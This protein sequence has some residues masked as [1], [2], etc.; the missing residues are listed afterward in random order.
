M[1]DPI[2]LRTFLAVVAE[3]GFSAAAR[4]LDLGQSTVSGHIA[5]LE[6]AAGRVL[7]RRDTHSV[8]LTADGSAMVGF[9][10][11]ILNECDRAAAYF[12]D[13][14]LAGRVRFGASED[15]VAARLPTVLRR[16]RAD[17]PRIELELTIGLS[18]DLHTKLRT[19]SLDVVL[20]KRNPGEQH[21]TLI[22]TEPLIWAGAPE[23]RIRSGE[24]VPLVTFPEPSISRTAALQALA[25][26]GLDHR[27]TCVSNNQ[28]G[29]RAAVLAGLG[30]M[31]HAR[32][33]LPPG[34]V[35]IDVLPDPGLTEVVLITRS[36]P[37]T[38]AEQALHDVLRSAQW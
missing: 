1:L 31:V 6:K 7:L 25:G 2:A 20:A 5:R 33:L 21:G 14:A 17:H 36:R 23:T 8:E 37:A 26:A 12:A 18:A 11:S 32:R 30:V 24:P 19:G 35:E 15:L 13:E 3:G 28:Q 10:R 38:P 16:F 34:L 9:A 4:S 29:L 22:F 27:V